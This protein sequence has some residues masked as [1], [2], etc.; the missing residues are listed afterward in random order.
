MDRATLE[1]FAR[2]KD[3][4]A[5][6]PGKLAKQAA[7]ADY[8]R[9]LADEDLPLAVRFAG[10]RAFAAKDERVLSVGG[11]IV[12]DVLIQILPV[13]HDELR[14]LTIASG[15]IGE[16]LSQV[17]PEQAVERA[18]TLADLADAFDELA[19]TGV[20]ERKRQLLLDLFKRCRTGRE[21]TYLAKIIFR[22][23]RTGAQEGVLQ[24]AVAQAF[25]QPVANIQR[26]QLLVGNLEEVALLAKH[27]QLCSATFRLFHPIQFMLATP[28]ETPADAEKTLAGRAFF[29]EDKLDGI[30][31]QVHKQGDRVSIYTRTMDRADDSFPEVLTAMQRIEGDFLLDGEIVPF[32]GGAVSPFAHLQR[33]LGRKRPTAAMLKKYPVTFIAFD[34]LYENGDLL[35]DKPLRE[36]RESLERFAARESAMLNVTPIAQVQT[37]TEIAAAFEAS[38]GRRNEGLILKDPE[39]IY[40]P[41]RRGKLWLK[42]KTHLPTLDCVVTAAEFGHGKRRNTLSDYTFAVW[43][44]E[45]ADDDAEL[46]NVGKAYSGVTDA[47]IAQLTELFKRIAIA[48]DGRVFH[49]PPQVVMEIAFDQIQRSTRHASG[50]ALRFPRIKTIRWDKRPDDADRLQRVEEIY[51][52]SANTSRDAGTAGEIDEVVREPT[53]FDHLP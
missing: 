23:M 6:V 28:Q 24:A 51:Q 11:A 25:S 15:E 1:D 39:S 26:C 37:A 46:V 45:P 5:A 22:D 36:R 21:A 30:R 33:R 41:G 50:F 35:M 13:G 53:L 42:L 48:N 4:V 12:W 52:S 27:D 19:E 10:G 17:W 14:R 8:F 16:A 31:A 20:Q 2:V 18:L 3:A 7:L 29:V 38:K 44:D 43:R 9:G 32:A 49:V 40:S 47:E 34:L